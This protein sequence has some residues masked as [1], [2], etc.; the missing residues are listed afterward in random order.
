MPEIVQFAVY[1]LY[2]GNPSSMIAV[3]DICRVIDKCQN[4]DAATLLSDR[5]VVP[6]DCQD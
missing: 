4:Y 1:T 3:Q 2:C 6:G 5:M